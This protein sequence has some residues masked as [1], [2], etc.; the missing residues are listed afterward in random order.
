[1]A[2]T[3]SISEKS[4]RPQTPV[5]RDPIDVFAN[6]PD[7]IFVDIFSK[8]SLQH[9]TSRCALVSK[10]W[11]KM[12]CDPAFWN[13]K[14][15]EILFS[16]FNIRIFSEKDW[17]NFADS[18][19]MGRDVEPLSNYEVFKAVGRYFAHLKEEKMYIKNGA[20]VTILT[21][22]K[23]LSV[24]SLVRLASQPKI[25]SPVRL[26]VL[27]DLFLRTHGKDVV[28]QTYR[29]IISNA[30]LAS[31][32]TS[33]IT[34]HKKLIRKSMELKLPRTLE[35][36]ALLVTTFAKSKGAIVLFPKREY[37]YCQEKFCGER[38]VSGGFHTESFVVSGSDDGY[39][40]DCAGVLRLES[41]PREEDEGFDFNSLPDEI[42]KE[43]FSHFSL[44][45]LADRIAPVSKRWGR[46]ASDPQLWDWTNLSR[47]FKKF[48]IEVFDE[49]KWDAYADLTS[50]GLDFS[51]L[52][53]LT[54]YEAFKEVGRFFAY[55]KARN[56]HVEG[57]AG[58][59]ILTLPQKFSLDVL[60]NFAQRPKVGNPVQFKNLDDEKLGELR[61]QT[62]SKSY[63]VIVTNNILSRTRTKNYD[64]KM[65]LMEKAGL[66]L[67]TTLE[68][69]TV[70][71]TM[72]VRS[73]PFQVR[74]FSDR[75]YTYTYCQEKI[76]HDRM[77]VGGF[78]SRGLDVDFQADEDKETQDMGTA[79]AW[80]LY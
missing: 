50:L 68:A 40:H 30:N 33:G 28:P 22:P 78:N 55:L 29:I 56:L 58:V 42:C 69:V 80:R 61:K 25:G 71:V 6:F 4:I 65:R 49:K 20:G 46:I 74:L 7:E 44:E 41:V 10:K 9:L 32:K 5:L 45:R 23:N 67:P 24:K 31:S 39:D 35:H 12:T 8:L 73:G 59:T 14:A 15:L 34:R 76:K 77:L 53:P 54:P 3:P 70:A 18:K 64:K 62:L 13:D 75:P 72:F 47:I 37:S 26:R 16:K 63:R 66:E 43:I 57:D 51:D 1:M 17:Q 48:K 19:G 21:I 79:A 2:L 60:M 27:W 36:M 11:E 38:L 52:M